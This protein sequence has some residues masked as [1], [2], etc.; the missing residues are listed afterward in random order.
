METINSRGEKYRL[1]TLFSS[2][3]A[4]HFIL[5]T[6]CPFFHK[7]VKKQNGV[8][9]MSNEFENWVSYLLSLTRA[10]YLFPVAVKEVGG[11]K[12]GYINAKGKI[13]LP[14]IYEDA[15]DFQE[16][17]LAIVRHNDHTGIINSDGYFIVKPKYDSISPFSEGRATVIDHQGFKVIDESGKE[18]TSKAYSFIG[19]YKE[20]RAIAA[21]TDEQGHYLYGYLN[22]RGREVIPLS[23]ESAN[24][25]R[26]GKALVQIKDKHFALIDLTGKV[27]SDF[28]YPSVANYSEGMLAFRQSQDGKWGFIDETGNIVIEPRFSGT[29]PFTEGYAIVSILTNHFEKYGLI[30]LQGKYIIKPQYDSL[31]NLEEG[32][33]ALGKARNPEKPYL[34]P[35][36]AIADNKGHIYTGFI[37]NGVSPFKDGIASAY[38]DQFT[39]FIDQRGMRIDSL[40]KVSGSGTLQFDKTLIKGDIDFRIIYFDK[41]GQVVWEHNQVIP[42]T[43]NTAVIENKYKP[44]K[45]YLVYYPQLRGINN[46]DNVNQQLKELAGVK[47]IPADIQLDSNYVGD[48][49]LPFYKKNLLVIEIKGYDYP[50]G[51]AHGMPVRKYAH[52]N[53]QTGSFYQLK[54]LFKSG[55]NYVKVISDIIANQIEN[56]EE[57]SYLFP[58]AYKGIQPDQPFFISENALNI[59][60]A[61][62][63][64]APFAAG[65][66]TFTIPFKQLNNIIAKDGSFWRSFH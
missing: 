21:D 38:N 19:D 30:D 54:D 25:F 23:Y 42:L 1:T 3:R 58:D 35:K 41:K 37:Y 57:Y 18:I 53:L 6:L 29:R 60:F 11:T 63:E 49:D 13:I 24:D 43:N 2:L 17:G 26:N 45:D 40:P 36:Y 39:F 5:D 12:W 46:Q 22:R 33:Y 51:A 34:F 55:S 8:V 4:A 62:Y 56:N 61:P 28:S 52:I 14:Y 7:I 32:R 20:G 15:Q 64:I 9:C 66:P 10:V 50:F 65:F 31:L 47:P 44:N 59:Y 16:N 27:L 48:F